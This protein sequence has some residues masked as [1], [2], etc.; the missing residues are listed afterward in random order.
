MGSFTLQQRNGQRKWLLCLDLTSRTAFASSICAFYVLIV[1]IRKQKRL[2][3]KS[4][5]AQ[6]F[7]NLPSGVPSGDFG[8]FEGL[9]QQS[10][11]PFLIALLRT[12]RLDFSRCLNDNCAA[13]L[14][15]RNSD[16]TDLH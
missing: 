1:I 10:G 5:G 14:F 11:D 13:S 4:P 9:Q 15:E 2:T 7:T 8:A 12:F 3:T 16:P 6:Q